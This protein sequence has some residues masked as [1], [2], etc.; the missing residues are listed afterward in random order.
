MDQHRCIK[1]GI[2][3]NR[4]LL[5]I[6]RAVLRLGVTAVIF[7]GVFRLVTW[8]HARPRTF[9]L[10]DV[11]VRRVAIVFGAG[12]YRDG[13]P[14]PVLRDRIR[15]AAQL[16]FDGK[17]EKLLLSGDNRFVYYNEPAAMRDFALGL[18]IPEQ[19]IVLDYAGRST[20][21][22]CYRAGA[23][24]QV[25]KA[26]LVTQ[27]FHLPRALY[28]CNALGMEAIGVSADRQRYRI[29]SRVVWHVRELPATVKAFVDVHITRPLPVLGQVESIFGGS[30]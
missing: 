26:I 2:R 11:P 25:D 3:M 5:F 23:I 20:Y 12:L 21:E 7:F 1:M 30:Q 4:L 29:S 8:L 10:A 13:T 18:G 22:T 28:T 27:G 14:T 19:A 16:Y 15:T 17:V 24:F 6:S 9:T